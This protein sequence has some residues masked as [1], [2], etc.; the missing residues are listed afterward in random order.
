MPLAAPAVVRSIAHSDEEGDEP[1][2]D[3]DE[4]DADDGALDGPGRAEATAVVRNGTRPEH[5]LRRRH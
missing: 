1:A 5:E 2:D 4:D 3:V